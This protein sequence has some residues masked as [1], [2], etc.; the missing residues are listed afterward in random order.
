MKNKLI[1]ILTIVLSIIFIVVGN[2]MATKDSLFFNED[3]KQEIIKTKIIDIN[4]EVEDNYS[5]GETE[6]IYQTKIIFTAEV[7]SGKYKGKIIEATQNVDTLL[8]V[9]AEKVSVGDK[10]L[11]GETEDVLTNTDWVFL[12][13]VRS[14]ALIILGVLFFIVLIV[15]GQLKGI[16]TIVSLIFTCLAI[17]MVFIPSILAGKNIYI[18]SSMT[19]IFI[20]IMTLLVVNGAS[21]KS[22]AAAI[23]CFSGIAVSGI[24]TI[25]MDKIIKLTGLVN[26]EAMYLQML[27][28]ENPI[29]LKAIVFASI[30]IGAIGAIMDVSM[31]ISSSLMEI[32][33]ASEKLKFKDLFNSGMNIGRD[34]M[35]TMANTL[36]LAYIGSS[37]SM[38]LLLIAYNYSFIELL[39]REMIVVEIL[40]SLVGSF[41]ILFTIP[42]TSLVCAYLYTNKK[43]NNNTI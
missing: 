22:L 13:Y 4:E 18:W 43:K 32:Y 27:S 41:G 21:K 26:D 1:Y 31:S 14:D 9:Q 29:D 3:N 25:I 19:C 12:E 8:A 34:I 42:L 30:I 36:I 28:T 38:T 23:G 11:L 15:F 5:L 40:Q 10:V 39:N 37:L 33:E 7:L 24:L 35:G 2:E 6:T 17:F 16:N 20:I